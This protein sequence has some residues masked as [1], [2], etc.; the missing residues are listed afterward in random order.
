LQSHLGEISDHLKPPNSFRFST[1]SSMPTLVEAIA[2]LKAMLHMSTKELRD[3]EPVFSFPI[4][5]YWEDTDAGGIVYYANYFKFF[6][7]TRTEWLRQLGVEQGSLLANEDSMFVVSQ[8]DAKYHKPARID[9][10]LNITL[11]IK[12]MG[13]A[14]ITLI[15]TAWIQDNTVSDQRMLACESTVRLACVQQTS[16]RPSKIPLR[17]AELLSAK[18]SN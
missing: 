12:H 4:R 9:D 18:L 17:V 6:E 10:L 14:S 5:I 16:M 15:Q 7:R 8:T 11:H 2:R 3:A 13:Q 1:A